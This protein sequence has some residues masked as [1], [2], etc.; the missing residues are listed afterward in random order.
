MLRTLFCPTG[1]DRRM[2]FATLPTFFEKAVGLATVHSR[3]PA[4]QWRLWHTIGRRGA[5]I[6]AMGSRSRA[7]RSGAAVVMR[8]SGLA[9]SI[10][11]SMNGGAVG[12]WAKASILEPALVRS[13]GFS[14]AIADHQPLP[15]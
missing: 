7:R 13:L 12:H 10:C 11:N 9:H 2:R 1:A 6:C 4:E 15:V 5:R 3:A 8:S 14:S